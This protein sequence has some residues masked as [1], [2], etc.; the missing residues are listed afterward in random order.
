L[1]FV[2]AQAFIAGRGWLKVAYQASQGRT[3]GL[4]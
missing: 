4:I 2:L 3:I 1:G